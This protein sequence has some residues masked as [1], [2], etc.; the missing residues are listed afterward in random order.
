MGIILFEDA[1]VADLSPA[2]LARPA[3]T[4]PCGGYRLAQLV[5]TLGERILHATR[6][7]LRGIVRNVCGETICCEEADLHLILNGR[8]VPS[9]GTLQSL[10]DWLAAAEP[11]RVVQEDV[12]VAALVPAST[13]AQ[14]DFDP[15]SLTKT[16][17]C[18]DLPVRE[19]TLPLFDHPHQI[20]QYHL[21]LLADNLAHRVEQG[22]YTETAL[23]TYLGAGATLHPSATVDASEGIILLERGVSVGPYSYLRGPLYLGAESAVLPHA[24]LGTH[25]AAENNCKLGGE[26]NCSIVAAY[27][28]K[29]HYG[30]LG[31]SYLGSWVNLGAG[32]TNSYLKNTYGE[33]SMQ[34]GGTQ[35]GTGMQFLGCLIGDYT[36]TAI[37]TAIL[38]GKTIGTCSMLY[39]TIAENIPSFVNYAKQFGKVTAVSPEVATTIQKRT[40]ERRGLA[41]E[42]ADGQFLTDLYA[43]TQSERYLF[44]DNLPQEP[45]VL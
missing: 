29:A 36:K 1:K 16:V 13:L 17:E 24:S 22:V 5:E 15:Q 42:P 28:N 30:F 11:G 43:L 37:G 6:P 40:Y 7:H 19:L 4:I 44:A 35:I 45:L 31:H 26:V 14:W 38:T 20:I 3:S 34:S 33:I 12:L 27:S 18:N 9:M 41:Q 25:V 39:G 21:D 2:T 32:T 10:R 8:C 23:G